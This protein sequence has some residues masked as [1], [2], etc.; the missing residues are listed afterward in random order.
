MTFDPADVHGIDIETE[1]KRCETLCDSY[2]AKGESEC[3]GHG[4]EPALSRV[5]EVAV[6]CDASV[7]GG[8]EVFEG[9]EDKI[10][11]DLDLF[12]SS[13]RPGVLAPWNGIFFDFPFISDR[14]KYLGLGLYGLMLRPAPALRPKYDALPG[15]A[16]PANP[17][18]GYH[19]YWTSTVSGIPHVAFDVAQGYK[20][21]ADTTIDP[22][23]G[24][25]IK[26]S[27]KPVA[28]ALGLPMF[29]IPDG[30]ADAD[31]F[32][33]RLHDADPADVKAYVTSD[34]SQARELALRL[35]GLDY[36]PYR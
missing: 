10:L 29:E 25:P 11:R 33:T 26:H 3:F 7:N 2:D 21:F 5:T 23:T 16:T 24:K 27:Q 14:V 31:D 8:G 4:L 12:L 34:A 30:F 22:A 13:L 35:M 36:A 15:H 6:A 19:A 17:G 9:K 28:E 32:R 1:N 18:G 20:R